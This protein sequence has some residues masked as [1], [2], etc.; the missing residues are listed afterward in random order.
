MLYTIYILFYNDITIFNC[1]GS[2][3]YQRIKGWWEFRS[4]RY[5]VGKSFLRFMLCDNN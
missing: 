1:I 4:H 5:S 3:I 2:R